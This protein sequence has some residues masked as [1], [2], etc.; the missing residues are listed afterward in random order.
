M[1][2]EVLEVSVTDSIAEALSSKEC[3]DKIVHALLELQEKQFADD[4]E[5][6]R[7]KK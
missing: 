7:I 5:E 2:K 3:V 6:K 1:K 4:G